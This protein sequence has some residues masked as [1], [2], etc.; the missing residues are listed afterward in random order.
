M[1][2]I[3][4]YEVLVQNV[5]IQVWTD[6]ASDDNIVFEGKLYDSYKAVEPYNY[7]RVV[8]IEVDDHGKLYVCVEELQ[9]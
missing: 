8:Q 5:D 6:A 2:L 7:Q 9:Y 3:N 4:L 1:D